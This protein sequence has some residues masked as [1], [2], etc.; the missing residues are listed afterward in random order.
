MDISALKTPYYGNGISTKFLG[1]EMIFL[2]HKG[3]NDGFFP[4]AVEISF[5]HTK[6]CGNAPFQFASMSMYLNLFCIIVFY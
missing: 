5:L 6:V 4:C 2:L 3:K 1:E